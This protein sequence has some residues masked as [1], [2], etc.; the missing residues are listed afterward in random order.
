MILQRLAFVEST[1]RMHWGKCKRRMVRQAGRLLHKRGL[2]LVLGWDRPHEFPWLTSPSS[3]RR[4]CGFPPRAAAEKASPGAPP[5]TGMERPGDAFETGRRV[6]DARVRRACQ[7]N[8]TRDIRMAWF[9]LHQ[10]SIGALLAA[11]QPEPPVIARGL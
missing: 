11:A 7:V 4:R 3:C 5:T 8:D 10:F 6:L 9:H 1:C 2:A